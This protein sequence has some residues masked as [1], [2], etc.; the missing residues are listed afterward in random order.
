[1]LSHADPQYAIERCF[2][3]DPTDGTPADLVVTGLEDYDFRWSE[4]TEARRGLDQR[5]VGYHDCV[6]TP[7]SVAGLL[8]DRLG[9]VGIVP[10]LTSDGRIGWVRLRTPC[11][12]DAES[13]ELDDQLWS[14][15]EAARVRTILEGEP[16]LNHLAVRHSF[17]YTAK[18]FSGTEAKIDFE[19]GRGCLAKVF[20]RTYEGR[21]LHIRPGTNPE[22]WFQSSAQLA[23]V[24]AGV[25]LGT[26]FG[27][28]GRI[29]P[30]V[31]IPCTYGAKRLLLGDIVLITH[32]C[33]VDIGAGVVG[34]DEELG[35]VVGA[36]RAITDDSP[37]HLIVMIPQSEAW[38]IAPCCHATAWNAGLLQLTI[39]ATEFA[40]TGEDDMTYFAAGQ[41]LRFQTRDSTVDLGVGTGTIAAGGV[42]IPAR[43]I[44]LVADPFG[45]A[46]PAGGVLV[47]FADWDEATATGQHDW[48]F[49]C[50]SAYG[51]GAAPDPGQRWGA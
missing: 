6:T 8:C 47:F 44:T 41:V 17:D 21:G 37:D 29:A 4:L 50:D 23:E 42:N 13:V 48:L 22:G 1:M 40:Q 2:G 15:V 32:P 14:V 45:G 28:F 10:R 36:T 34:V 3:L 12:V 43:T 51:L 35:V 26:H 27:L 30:L 11:A 7:T 5:L 46:F 19:D 33:V 24:L 20:G 39:A 49:E 25:A 9:M 38:P 31:D 16:L 18:E